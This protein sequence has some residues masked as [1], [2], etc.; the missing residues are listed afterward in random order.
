MNDDT[1]Y[2]RSSQLDEE[3]RRLVDDRLQWDLKLYAAE[4]EDRI[5]CD[6]LDYAESARRRGAAP[7]HAAGQKLDLMEFYRG[8]Y[9][10]YLT[11]NEEQ[12]LRTISIQ[13]ERLMG[14]LNITFY[15]S[16]LV[17][18]VA[19]VLL[20]YAADGWMHAVANLAIYGHI[21]LFVAGSTL[22][23][24]YAVKKFGPSVVPLAWP[25]VY[26]GI[27]CVYVGAWLVAVYF[28]YA[29]SFLTVPIVALVTGGLLWTF[30][31]YRKARRRFKENYHEILRILG[32]P[33]V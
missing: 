20:R 12:W 2:S 7:R 6:Y 25:N 31:A 14:D 21:Y 23:S 3:T 11:R 13:S 29:A 1:D 18:I 27:G 33:D 9:P 24:R 17:M 22:L 8:S 30:F 16:V 28:F 15:A 19:L 10:P 32:L 26:A 5:R 4:C